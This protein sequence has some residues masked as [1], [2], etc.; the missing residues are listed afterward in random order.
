MFDSS[1]LVAL[2]RIV[3]VGMALALTQ[4]CMVRSALSFRASDLSPA[5]CVLAI[6]LAIAISLQ[7]LALLHGGETRRSYAPSLAVVL[8]G[9]PFGIAARA[10]GGC[11]IGTL[12]QLCRGHWRRLYTLAG[13]KPSSRKAHGRTQT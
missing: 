11:Y 8:G 3:L 7:L 6:S 5:S 13:S 2:A 9:L 4:F 10:N 1:T 12:N